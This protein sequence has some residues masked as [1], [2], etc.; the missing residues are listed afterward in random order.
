MGHSFGG[1][2]AMR[3]ASRYPEH[4]R[5]LMLVCS[6]A[7]RSG[8]A[9]EVNRR[10]LERLTP[11]RREQRAKLLESGA[12]ESGDP[13]A[14]NTFMHLTLSSLFHDPDRV[15]DLHLRIGDDAD[16]RGAALGP[17]FA[18]LSDFDATDALPTI[19]APTLIVRGESDVLPMEATARIQAGIE[20][21]VRVVLPSC[22]HFPW[23]ECPE[24]LED[25]M[26]AFLTDV[27]ARE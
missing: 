6:T 27:R 9:D 10:M 18:Y 25:A 19:V 8:Y 11:E 1:L 3:Y 16:E 14:M 5:S 12:L 23:V 24:A 26:G 17:I 7:A 22:G 20:G 13:S 15:G 4:V 2:L 21:S